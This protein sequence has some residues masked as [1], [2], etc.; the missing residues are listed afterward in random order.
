MGILLISGEIILIPLWFKT[1]KHCKKEKLPSY[2]PKTCIIVPCKGV[3]KNFRKNIQA[4]C[5]QNYKKYNI[6]FVTDSPKDPAYKP[7]KDMAVGNPKIKIQISDYIQGCSGK[8][9]ALI[10]GIKTS[11]DVEV[12]VFAD[13]DIKPHKDWLRYLVSYLNDEKTGATTGYRWYFPH[14]L[15]S[16]LISI[17]N[18]LGIVALFYNKSN[19]TW[20]GSTAIKKKL[21]E[22]LDIETKW[23][24]GF[25][26]DL[27]LTKELKK[28]GYRIKFVPQCIVESSADDIIHTFMQW[29]TRQFTLVQWYFPKFRILS[30]SALF[31]I[32]LFM[33][34]GILLVSF[35]FVL[36]GLL[37]LFWIFLATLFGWLIVITL[38]K[39]MCYPKERLGSNV[40]YF[41]MMPLAL[42]LMT[43]NIF[44]SCFKRQILWHERLYRKSDVE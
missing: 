41:V 22:K 35:G 27:I 3:E 15:K 17:W 13:A 7:L 14:N 2:Y 25:S 42:F 24:K 33:A 5:N 1:L 34:L 26:D 43:C 21:F 9:S 32:T 29:G 23:R 11:G 20:G 30:L 31:G 18:A 37:I 6:V 28:A 8:I 39:L 4:I 38:R 44:V 40:V 19:Y 10:K 16:Y 36:P 12:Y